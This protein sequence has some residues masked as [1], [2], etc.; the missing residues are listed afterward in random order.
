MQEVQ[1]RRYTMSEETRK[2]LQE[3]GRSGA[4]KLQETRGTDTAMNLVLS[5]PVETKQINKMTFDP[6]LFQPMK[7]DKAIDTLLSTKGGLPRAVN[8]VVIGDPG[9]GKTTIC[10]DVLSDLT[11]AGFSGLYV[12][13]EMTDIDLKEYVDRYPKFGDLDILIL[14]EYDDENPKLVLENIF[15]RGYEIIVLDSLAEIIDTVRVAL[16]LPAGTAEKWVVDQM[17]HQNQGKNQHGHYTSFLAIQQV[18]KSGEFVGSNKLKHNTTGM[19]EIRYDDDGVSRYCEFSKNRRGDSN[20]KMYF[21]LRSNDDVTYDSA[22]WNL[23]E[24]TRNALSN[25]EDRREEES[26]N[27]LKLFEVKSDGTLATNSPTDQPQPVSNE[28]SDANETDDSVDD[29][30]E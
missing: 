5:R 27:F 19:L 9:V 29:S 3:A 23:D 14:S 24:T 1:K 6:K 30:V 15:Q 8:Y 17:I 28:S 18:N 12:S 4:A 11:K 22:R 2:K 7:T 16:K 26:G 20:K 21:N 13:A 10:L 25:E